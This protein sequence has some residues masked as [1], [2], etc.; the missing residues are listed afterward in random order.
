M[1]TSSWTK[2]IQKVCKMVSFR[3]KVFLIVFAK[4]KGTLFESVWGCGNVRAVPCHY[5]VVK[6][7]E[8]EKEYNEFK[9][10]QR[11]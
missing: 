4:L 9:L 3:P 6:S 7:K 5:A 1:V 2:G 10:E 11:L 8:K